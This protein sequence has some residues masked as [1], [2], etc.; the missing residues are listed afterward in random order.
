MTPDEI[1]ERFNNVPSA[2]ELSKVGAELKEVSKKYNRLHRR[3]QK[4]AI[5]VGKEQDKVADKLDKEFP[6]WRIVIR[7][8]YNEMVK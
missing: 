4:L 6:E 8:A 7:N 1:N 5:D 2:S 3:H